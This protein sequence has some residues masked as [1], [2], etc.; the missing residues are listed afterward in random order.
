L[1]TGILAIETATDACSIAVIRGD[2]V[3]ER[4]HVEPRIHSVKLFQFLQELLPSGSLAD[5]NIGAIAYGCGPG[6]FTGLRVAASAVA[7]LAWT[8]N[9]PAVPISSLAVLAQTA[10]A[11]GAYDESMDIMSVIDARIKEVYAAVFKVERGLVVLREGPWA[12]AP[13]ELLSKGVGPL[14]MVGD[15]ARFHDAFPSALRARIALVDETLSPRAR[16]MAALTLDLLDRQETQTAL[17]VSP[18]YLREEI[19][20]KKIA[21]QGKQH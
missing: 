11:T 7:G 20:W 2:E 4:H 8:G 12:C 3:V 14:Y 16:Y 5:N 18:V 19:N 21:D 13:S 9:V 17:E 1:S 10:F 6:S 15:G